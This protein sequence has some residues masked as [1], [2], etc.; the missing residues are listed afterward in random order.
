MPEA[1]DRRIMSLLA[2]SYLFPVRA[3]SGVH[4]LGWKLMLPAFL[5]H[6]ARPQKI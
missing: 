1:Q 3:T 5:L 6:R 2:N 4:I